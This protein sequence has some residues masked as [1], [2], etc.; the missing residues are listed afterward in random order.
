MEET[1]A[2]AVK[3]GL[4]IIERNLNRITQTFA[5]PNERSLIRTTRNDIDPAVKSRM[6][7][8]IDSMFSE[9]AFLKKTFNLRKEEE[10]A[11][12]RI[13]SLISET[14]TV[15]EDCMPQKLTAYGKMT[16]ADTDILNQHIGVLL[17]M[18]DQLLEELR[19]AS[20]TNSESARTAR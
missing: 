14:W 13:H 8:I 3:S 12:W 6:L 4:Y 17:K 1:V 10:S 16:Q 15:L 2:S 18:N 19:T 9:I 20:P 7:I 11:S 5:R